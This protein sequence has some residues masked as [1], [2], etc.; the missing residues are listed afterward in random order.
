MLLSAQNGD[1]Q[2]VETLFPI[3]YGELRTIAHRQL[4]S[5]PLARQICT[6]ELVHEAYLKLID[7]AQVSWRSRTHFFALGARVMRQLL[8][9]RARQNQAVKRGGGLKTISLEEGL[10]TREDDSHVLAV[11]EA[12]KR[13][14]EVSS[15]QAQIVE[16][17]FFG[18]M[19]VA[20]VAEELGKSKRW[21]EA[22][23][24]MIRAWLRAELSED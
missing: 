2:A 13:L 9:D 20:E 23:W 8:I 22:E 4:W 3:V 12:L 17:R 1:S 7:Q 15:E 24:T 6:T 16:M 5:N 11:D 19:T 21:V 14:E 18:G 10:L